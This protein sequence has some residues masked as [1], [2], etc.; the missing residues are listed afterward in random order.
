MTNYLQLI[1]DLQPIDVVVA[2]K[3]QGFGRIL[4]HYIVYLDNGVFIGNLKGAVKQVSHSELIELLREY[5]PVKIRKFSGSRFQI[6]QAIVR[7]K[8][9]LGHKYSFLGFNCEHF[10]NWVQYGKETS[11]QVSNGFLLVAG[12]ITVKIL[13]NNNGKR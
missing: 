11:S 3:R 1:N 8:Q 10:A 9:K 5:E 2:K 13:A 12:L 4:N 6:Q 7:A